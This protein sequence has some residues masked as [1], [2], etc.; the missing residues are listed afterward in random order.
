VAA[1]SVDFTDNALTHQVLWSLGHPTDKLVTGNACI[2]V[3][4]P[5]QFEIGIADA[6]PQNLNQRFTRLGFRDGML[7]TQAELL[8]F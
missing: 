5:Q 2:G 4:P 8:V 6:S 1:G 3:I 7:G